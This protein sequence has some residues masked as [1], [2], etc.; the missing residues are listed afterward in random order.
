[1]QSPVVF[2][3]ANVLYAAALRD[4]LIE[5]AVAKDITIRWSEA[6]HQ[7]WTAALAKTRPDLKPE[8]IQRT[9][10]LLAAALPDA[11]VADSDDLIPALRPPDPDDRHVLAA[12]IKGEC[13]V[14]LTFNLVDFPAEALAPHNLVAMHPDTFLSTLCATNPEPLIS[15]AARIRGRL[16]RPPMS[17]ADYLLALTQGLLPATAQV[18]APFSDKI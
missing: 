4:L 2:T 11:T 9:L 8:R 14:I 5:L 13:Q 17:P 15:A 10:R 12:A 3:D 18:L 7:E 16:T 6:V 1:M